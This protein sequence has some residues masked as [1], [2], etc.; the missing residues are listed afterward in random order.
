MIRKISGWRRLLV[1][2]I[3]VALAFTAFPAPSYATSPAIA[4]FTPSSRLENISFENQAKFQLAAATDKCRKVVTRGSDL[5]VRSGP[6][7]N[8]RIIGFVKNG[9]EVTLEQIVNQ[10]WAKISSPLSGYISQQYLQSCPPPPKQECRIVSTNTGKGLNVRQSPGGRIIGDLDN[11]T[12]VTIINSITNG[13]VQL[14]SPQ[15]GYVSDRYLK[16]CPPPPPKEECRLVSTKG[17][18]LNVRATPGGKIVGVVENGTT[19]TIKGTSSD[20]WVPMVSPQKGYV[21]EAYLQPCPIV[22]KECGTVTTSGSELMVRSTPGGPSIGTLKNGT[23]VKIESIR[24]D[25]WVKISEPIIGYVSGKFIKIKPCPTPP[26][27]EENCREV[28]A[29][30]GL[31]VRKSPSFDGDIIGIIADG[32]KVTIVNRGSNGWVPISAPLQGYVTGKYLIYCPEFKAQEP[33]GPVG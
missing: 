5:N 25:G 24:A 26:P 13:W 2:C 23:E 6:G 12:K 27:S 30:Q 3:S 20:G 11:G 4:Q 8:Y 28:S 10:D 22:K 14:V 33:S 31:N 7:S 29:P 18:P 32:S 9:S 16:P 15:K 17:N 21:S 19:I 1:V